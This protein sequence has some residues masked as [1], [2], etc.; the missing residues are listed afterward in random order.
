M[1]VISRRNFLLGTA[2]VAA[3]SLLPNLFRSSSAAAD[4]AALLWRADMEAASFADYRR[5]G[6]P[7]INSMHAS[8]NSPVLSRE[9]ARCGTQSLKFVLN[10]A[11]SST[12]YRTEASTDKNK[13]EFFKT[14]WF[15]FSIFIPH[16]WRI[17][18]TW[19]VLFQF[20]HHPLD[21]A[22]A[23]GGF[24][25]L[26]AIR[27]DSNSDQYLVRQ[28]YVQTPEAEHRRGDR[29]TAFLATIP[30]ALALGRW[31]D[32]VLEYRPDWRP[33]TEGGRG[34]TRFWRD[35]VRVIDY[36]GPNAANATY[37]PYLKFGT[38]KSRWKD[39]HYD[40]PVQE[41]VYYF[42]ELRVSRA[43][44]GSY[45]LVAPGRGDHT[46]KPPRPPGSVRSVAS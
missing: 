10:R 37:T 2:G 7:C 46:M 22:T 24:S 45:E 23:V 3:A 31:T 6:G 18:S 36:R 44:E 43:D 19:E 11:E 26:L 14:H 35:G 4:D 17:S 34:V 41:R 25:P 33:V 20:H 29:K 32:W 30:G 40:D 21:W 38:Y 28:N 16:S 27:L 8:G 1:S 13:L 12:S 39:R 15:G 5:R 9:Q 42:D